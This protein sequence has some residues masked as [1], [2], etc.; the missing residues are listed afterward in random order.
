MA[1]GDGSVFVGTFITCIV[2][3]LFAEDLHQ[4]AQDIANN[5]TGLASTLYG[6]V[7]VF[8]A[9]ILIAIMAGTAMRAMRSN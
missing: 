5:T 1:N 4:M 9:L 8:Y 2:G 6:Y 7:G 3:L